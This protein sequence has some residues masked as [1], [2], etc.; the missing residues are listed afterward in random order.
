[1]AT[2]VQA[3]S[4]P[5]GGHRG[6][7]RVRRRHTASLTELPLLDEVLDGVITFNTVYDIAELD[8]VFGELC[9][10]LNRTGRAVRGLAD[11]ELMAAR[12]L[13]VR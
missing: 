1:M 8:Q 5:A 9:R 10:V 13:T 12:P 6:R 7:S 4:L 2:A 11:P 3:L